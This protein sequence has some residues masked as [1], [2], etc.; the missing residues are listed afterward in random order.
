MLNYNILNF[1][2][3]AIS[4]AISNVICA[5]LNVLKTRYEVVGDK[6]PKIYQSIQTIYH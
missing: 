6:N 1:S 3:A 4:K 5:P 2:S